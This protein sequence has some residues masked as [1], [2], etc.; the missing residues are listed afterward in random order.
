MFAAKKAKSMTRKKPTTSATQVVLQ[1]QR[2]RATTAKIS[3]VMTM[4]EVT[5]IPYAAARWL[6]VWKASTT[7]M[8]ASIKSQLTMGI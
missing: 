8:Q 6:E 3:V 4:V 7:A 2:R 1:C 5:A